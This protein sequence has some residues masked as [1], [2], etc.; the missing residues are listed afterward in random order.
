MS[1]VL[2]F[3][4]GVAVVAGGSGGIGAAIA[5]AFGAAG[6]PVLLS[7]RHNAD[8]ALAVQAD[9][10]AAGG[11]C[12]VTCIDLTQPAQADELLATARE[13]HARVGQVVFAAGA[14]FDFGFIGDIPDADW[15]R[16]VDTD[17]KGAFH[18]VQSALRVFRAQGGGNLVAITTAAVGRIASGDILSA[19]PKAAVET[20][21][22]GAAKEAGRFGVRANCV[23]PGWID[24]GLGGRALA[25]Q[26]DQRQRDKV[27]TEVIPLRRFGEAEEVSFATLFL[28]SRQ[29]AF[30]TGQSLAV[31]GG[32]QI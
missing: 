6:V 15:G 2:D 30:I 4:D 9:I 25:E 21:I 27:R 1:P 13:S 5:R 31:D 19:A 11:T 29:A 26:L 14:S 24:A 18:L 22:R 3:D 7:Y 10:C 8:G 20:L 16:V 17:V 32:A 12:A 28:C 23:Q